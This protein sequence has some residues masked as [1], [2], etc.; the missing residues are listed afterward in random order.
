MYP[1]INQY[2]SSSYLQS[3]MNSKTSSFSAGHV[4][5]SD[6]PNS[7]AHEKHSSKSMT[8]RQNAIPRTNTQ[9]HILAERK[10]R[11]ELTKNIVELSAD[12]TKSKK[13]VFFAKI[14]SRNKI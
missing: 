10:R 12:T 3:N 8:Q 2:S 9:H 5:C 1:I 6:N 4:L 7:E 14:I 11:E 13:S